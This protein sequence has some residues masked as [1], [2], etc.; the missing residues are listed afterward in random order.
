M[1]Q[2]AQKTPCDVSHRCSQAMFR[3][4]LP[5]LMQAQGRVGHGSVVWVISPIP[6]TGDMERLLDSGN[7]LHPRPPSFGCWTRWHGQHLRVLAR[8]ADRPGAPAGL[9]RFPFDILLE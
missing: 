7:F 4:P 2:L 6:E 9:W 3:T 1:V 8:L 5:L